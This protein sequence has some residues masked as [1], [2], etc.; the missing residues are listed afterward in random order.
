M[1]K[2][3][4]LFTFLLVVS[5][6]SQAVITSNSVV[7]NQK[8]TSVI[9]DNDPA[10]T[11]ETTKTSDSKSTDDSSCSK[12]SCDKSSCDKKSCDKKEAAEQK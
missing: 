9:A 11:G 10:K 6:S 4:V 7:V 1:K 12:K 2:I 8:S 5:L 3:A